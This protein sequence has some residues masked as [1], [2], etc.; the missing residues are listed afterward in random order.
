[1]ASVNSVEYDVNGELACIS[2]QSPWD[3][4]WNTYYVYNGNYNSVAAIARDALNATIATSSAVAFSVHN[5]LPETVSQMAWTVST[6]TSPSSPWTG[7]V[8]IS[9]T[10]TGTNATH[11]KDIWLMIDG[12]AVH[13]SVTTS[14]TPSDTV[15][16]CQFDNGV[17]NVVWWISDL[18]T[19][20]SAPNGSWNGTAMWEK[21]VDFEC[22]ATKMELRNSTTNVYLCTTSLTNCPTTYTLSSR[23]YNTDQT[24]ASVSPSFASDTPSV[25]TVNSS[26]GLITQ[27]AA[28]NA[29]ITVTCD[30]TCSGGA[31]TLTRQTTVYVNTQNSLPHFGSDGSILQT[32]DPTKSIW[33]ASTFESSGQ[34]K[35]VDDTG[36]YPAFTNFQKDYVAAAFNTIEI[37]CG[38]APA[39]GQSETAWKSQE[40]SDVSTF[41]GKISSYP[42]LRAFIICDS[43]TRGTPEMQA[44]MNGPGAS[45]STPAIQYMLQ[46]W[47]DT[48]LTLGGSWNDEVQTSWAGRPDVTSGL[49]GTGPIGSTLTC[50]AGVNCT[51]TWTNPSDYFVGSHT[52]IITGSGDSNLDYNFSG[53]AASYFVTYVGNSITFP[54]PVGVGNHTYTSGTNPGLTFNFRVDYTLNTSGAHSGACPNYVH[55]SAFV[56]LTAWANAATGHPAMSWS[57]SA[58]TSGISIGNWEGSSFSGFVDNYNS[59]GIG[60]LSYLPDKSSL[61]VLKAAETTNFNLFYGSAVT[62]RLTPITPKSE[63]IMNIYGFQGAFVSVSNITAGLATFSSPH[64]ISTVIPM[65]SRMSITGTSSGTHDGNFWVRD[66]PTSTTCNLLYQYFKF[67]EFYPDP[68]GGLATATMADGA[69]FTVGQIGSSTSNSLGNTV[70]LYSIAPGD[71]VYKHY[72][73]TFTIT[74]IAGHNI[75]SFAG[76]TMWLLPQSVN[77]TTCT[78]GFYNFAQPVTGSST[79]GTAQIIPNNDYVRGR[80]WSQDSEGGPAMLFSTYVHSFLQGGGGTRNYQLGSYYDSPRGHYSSVFNDTDLSTQPGLHP[81]YPYARA[82]LGWQASSNAAHLIQGLIRMGFQQRLP[83]PDLGQY[84]ECTVRTS[85]TYGN[86][87]M[88]MSFANGTLSRTIDLTPYLESGQPIIKYYATWS[89]IGISTISAGTTSDF[90]TCEAGCV[91]VYKFPVSASSEYSPPTLSVRLADVPNAAKV[92]VQY[93]YTEGIFKAAPVTPLALARAVDCGAGS[94]CTLPLDRGIGPVFYK[95]LYLDASGRVIAAS[96]VQTL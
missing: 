27:V 89:G 65:D 88:C 70:T 26:S 13:D 28:G 29:T 59:V 84:F 49:I 63:G 39:W 50:V 38:A 75:G 37:G 42:S 32:Y 24:S 64:G 92:V 96:D 2:H 48:N 52:M 12:R 17:H 45:Y 66:C 93:S 83:P 85:A 15:H 67:Q 10:V 33:M 31:G 79:G 1:M 69:T 11:N 40:D 73:E 21:Q 18:Q 16:A 60:G 9:A 53:C 61:Y 36:S 77:G 62:N 72:S 76:L 82:M 20:I 6:G 87:L 22:G 68:G 30:N 14:T 8:T 56:D 90:L 47:R 3:C 41:I 58:A 4:E 80:N 55:N 19:P 78:A 25:A 46:K 7:D 5:T 57:N 51:I 54:T 74:P 34:N 43:M 35:G 71:C 23:L 86:M 91:V 81:R 44:T 95:L 94:A